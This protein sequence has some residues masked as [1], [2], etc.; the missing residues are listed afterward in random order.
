M[1]LVEPYIIAE[2]GSNLFKHDPQYYHLTNLD[3]GVSQIQAAK[4]SGAD[5]VKFQMFTVKELYGPSY[6][7]PES[8]Y[9][10]PREWVPV[11]AQECEKVGIDFMCSAFS[12]DGYKFI[13]RYVKMHKVASPEAEAE[14]IC[15]VIFSLRP[16]P[17]LVST[18]CGGPLIEYDNMIRMTCASKY[19]AIRSDYYLIPSENHWGVSDHTMGLSVVS[20]ARSLG[21]TYFER[22]VDFF[23]GEGLDT[24]D[25][26]VSFSAEAFRGWVSRI[27]AVQPD[28]DFKDYSAVR[29]KYGRVPKDGGWYRPWPEG[30]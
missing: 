6:P 7:G 4:E 15:E 23:K 13:D 24:P 28:D 29:K 9:A 1:T 26:P 30:E 5:A 8:P 12:V 2:I 25:T 27:R 19:P 14:D 10:L 3:M 21:A 16:K 11:L 20:D 17:T 18:G 22:H